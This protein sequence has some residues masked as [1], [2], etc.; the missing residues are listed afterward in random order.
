MPSRTPAIRNQMIILPEL[1]AERVEAGPHAARFFLYLAEMLD[2]SFY[3]RLFIIGSPRYNR[4][5][6]VAVIFY[7]MYKGH[8]EDQNIVQFAQDSIG[9]QWILNGMSMP[10]YKTVERTIN[11]ILGELDSV[12]TQILVLCDEVDLI[13]GEI[14]YIDG[15]KVQANASK[16]K[17]MS[18]EYLGKKIERGT[19]DL[20]TLF[21]VL[22]GIV[23][24]LED[25]TE[26]EL[27]DIAFEDAAKVHKGLR[28]IHQKALDTRQ[29]KIFNRDYEETEG[30]MQ[31]EKAEEERAVEEIKSELHILENIDLEKHCDAIEMLNN[32]AFVHKRVSRME[33][34]K[35]E[36][37]DRWKKEN[38]N[39]KIPDKKQIN[40]TDSDSCIM[41]T[42]HHGVQQCYNNFAVVDNKANIILGCYTNNNPVDQLG[43][44]PCVKRTEQTYGSMKGMK[45]AGDAG[46]FC[47]S[48]ISYC[49]GKEIDFYASYPE[50]KSSYAKD[51]FKY[52]ESSD[53]YIC[54]RGNVLS[55]TKESRDEKTHI[56]SNKEACSL[57]ENLNDCTKAKDGI[58]KIS[59]DMEDDKLREEGREKANSAEGRE[60]LRLRKSVPE[61]VWGNIKTQDGFIQMHYRGIDKAG[62]EFELHC[63]MQ[64]I[65]KLLKVYF[66]SK[67]YQDIVHKKTGGYCKVA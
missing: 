53:T 43:L 11:D 35:A 27:H 20:K 38:G 19:E 46:F 61:P 30:Q 5:T 51:K 52:N 40:F 63:I 59:R 1:L 25:I 41:Q 4:P 17:A 58:R 39:K 32:I 62:L 7:A 34:A 18:Y 12:F 66:K 3:R 23:D 36:L 10:S 2:L 16:H 44:I 33:E 57:C 45:F 54:P 50:A 48:N 13:G 31:T 28:K 37:E 47:A 64:N 14:G 60:I 8:F 55:V 6:L 15:V 56:Y 67:S 21:G 24:S 9:A 26:E 49:K 65:R 22:R 29:D 42:K